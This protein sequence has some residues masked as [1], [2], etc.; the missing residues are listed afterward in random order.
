MHF[1]NKDIKNSELITTD[2]VNFNIQSNI[3][4]RVDIILNSSLKTQ[5]SDYRYFKQ[6]AMG[7]IVVL[8]GTSTAGKTSIIQALKELESDRIEDGGDIRFM[9]ADLK[10]MT[11]YNKNEIEILKRVMKTDL[12]IPSAV[13]CKERSWKQGVSEEE[14]AQAEEAILKIKKTGETLDK[15]EVGAF[16]QNLEL[17]MIT[18]AFERSRHGGTVIFDLLRI[19]ALVEQIFTKN[20]NGPV[21]IALAYCPFHKLSSRMEKR[22]RE[23][24]ESGQLSNQRIGAFPL[25]QFGE[26]YTQKR[27]NQE[28]LESITREQTIKAFNDNFD[29][30]IKTGRKNGDKLP[31]DNQIAKDKDRARTEL[32]RNLGFREGSDKVE[33]APRNLPF[34][35][36]IL[37]TNDNTA[38]ESA[39]I[40]HEG[41][42]KRSP[43]YFST[44]DK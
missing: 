17:E 26:I 36:L 3:N 27:I 32:L 35:N 10:A 11:K 23:A 24:E 33:I 34:Y 6:Y 37:N 2:N 21:R 28:T 4:K 13:F 8:I 44:L 42:F 39:K 31:S 19:E 43:N 25:L 5:F 29:N 40:L 41:T 16:F 1:I 12:D 20:F 18:D 15:E 38:I 14:K 22:N 9:T 30:G 7:D